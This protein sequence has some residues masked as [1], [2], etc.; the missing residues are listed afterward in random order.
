MK[1]GGEE[2]VLEAEQDN[3][4]IEE[5]LTLHS[6]RVPARHAELKLR[7]PKWS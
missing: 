4:G 5:F 6:A 1:P 2:S 7:T 3:A